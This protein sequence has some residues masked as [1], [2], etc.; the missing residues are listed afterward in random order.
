MKPDRFVVFCGHYTAL[1][2]AYRIVSISDDPQ[3]A[4]EEARSMKKGVCFAHAYV[5]EGLIIR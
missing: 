4:L 2:H 3:D 5:H 1:P